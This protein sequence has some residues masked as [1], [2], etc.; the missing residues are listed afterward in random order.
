M[1]YKWTEK[2]LKEIKELRG[3]KKRRT[4]L[5]KQYERQGWSDM[6][7]WNLDQRFAIWLLPRL[8][9]FYELTNGYPVRYKSMAQWKKE[10]RKM[11][12]AIEW[13]ASEDYYV[14]GGKKQD[15]K[16]TELNEALKFFGENCRDLW[17]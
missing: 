11:I 3:T 10:L 14:W 15:K 1:A 7:T 9:R 13:M 5:T 2:Q 6:E 12:K 8:I 16:N 17:W 4:R